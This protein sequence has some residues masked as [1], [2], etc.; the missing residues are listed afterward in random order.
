MTNKNKIPSIAPFH[1]QYSSV[2]KESI[3]ENYKLFPI[4]YKSKEI[5]EYEVLFFHR[6]MKKNYGAPSQIEPLLDSIKR[7]EDGRMTALG[8]EWKYYI[9]T[10]SGGIIQIGTEDVHT[11][12]KICHVLPSNQDEPSGRLIREGEKFIDDFLREA[13]RLKDQILNIQKEFENDRDMKVKVFFL[14]NVY[15]IN[16][17]S[18]ELMLD[19]AEDNESTIIDESLRYDARDALTPE[20][21]AHLDKFMPAVG[22]YFGAAI[23]YYFMALEGFINFLYY[24]FLKDE[25]RSEFFDKEPNLDGRLDINAKVLLM[26]SLCNGFKTKQTAGFLKDLTRLKNYRNFS[27]HS[28]ISYSLKRVGFLESGFLYTCNLKGDS[29]MLLP[30][31]RINLRNSNVLEFK[32]IVDSIIKDTL[33][34]MQEDSM[35]LVEKWILNELDIPFRKDENG[36][37]KLGM[38]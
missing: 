6:L 35:S 4:S 28:K 11:L 25:L 31:L 26:P 8:R 34:M 21:N 16:Y 32:E 12:L 36:A 1:Y 7:S 13:Q 23:S 10:D 33:G 20:Q 24:A 2:P 14:H 30:S 19:Y 17:Q 37:I 29:S 27:F 5:G 3:P 38:F 15:L 18:A 22:M 9:R